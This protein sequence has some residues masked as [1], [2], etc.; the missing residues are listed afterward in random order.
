MTQTPHRSTTSDKTKRRYDKA[1]RSIYDELFEINFTDD[2]CKLIHHAAGKNLLPAVKEP[3]SVIIAKISEELICPADKKRFLHFF[4][5]EK[6]RANFVA[7]QKHISGEFRKLQ[8]D[9]EYH[10]ISL[11]LLPMEPLNGK[12]IYLCCLADIDNK[13]QL[14]LLSETTH[15]IGYDRLTGLP[16]KAAFY[17]KARELLL[18]NSGLQYY[19]ILIDIERFKLVN[20]LFG[21]LKGDELLRYL[22]NLLDDRF[23]SCNNTAYCHMEADLFAVCCP[24]SEELLQEF[25]AFVTE[26]LKAYPL[27]F[28]L[29]PN[30]GVYKVIEA[31]LP[32][33]LM[34][35]RALLA[36]RTIKDSCIKNH[37]FYENKLRATLLQKQE[38][39]GQME[40]ALKEGQFEI[41]LQPKVHLVTN[42]IVGVEALARWNHP[43]KGFLSPAEFIPI[44]EQ[45]G[46]ITKLDAYIWEESCFLLRKWLDAGYP[47]LPISVNVSRLDLF[48]PSL[49]QT[50]T[51]LVEKYKLDPHLLNLE[52]TETACMIRPEELKVIT[53]KLRDYGFSIHMDD[54]GSGYSAL[55]MLQDIAVDTLKLD[56]GFLSGF[57]KSGRSRSI[58]SSV[59]RM[60][61]WLN[62]PVIVEGVETEEQANFLRGIGCTVAQGYYFSEPLPVDKFE[63]TLRD[64]PLPK[65]QNNETG[66]LGK[67]RLD[68]VWMPDSTFN[69]IFDS[70][71]DAAGIYEFTDNNIELLRANDA[72]YNL[73]NANRESLYWAGTHLL[74]YIPDE[75]KNI[76]LAMITEAREKNK[77]EGTYRRLLPDGTTLW[78][79]ARI[80][81]L[82]G[83][84]QRA[85]CYALIKDVTPIKELES[86]LAENT[87]AQ[88]KDR[89]RLLAEHT[90]VMTYEY[91]CD[92]GTITHNYQ[93]PAGKMRET[94]I[95]NYLL[96]AKKVSSIHPDDLPSFLNLLKAKVLNSRETNVDFRADFFGTGY[97]WY[98][99]YSVG[100]PNESGR[101]YR[102][103]GKL[104]DIQNEKE[105]LEQIYKKIDLDQLTGIFTK[106]AAQKK[107]QSLLTN[108]AKEDFHALLMIDLDNFKEVND[109]FGHLFGDEVLQKTS[110]LLRRTFGDESIIGRFGG[111]EFTVMLPNS[112]EELTKES[113]NS[114]Y[115]QLGLEQ[116]I[117]IKCST[118][119]AISDSSSRDYM[120]LLA[121]ADSAMYSAKK[122]GK[123]RFAG[124]QN[125]ERN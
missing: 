3:F 122:G 53:K 13:K 44:F 65:K 92:S 54:F 64:N 29:I 105:T 120:C 67:T 116:D 110:S 35:D 84:E 1:L 98:R 55:N 16:S 48:D 81:L 2:V 6:I 60:T 113:L 104:M 52:I 15:H 27:V 47:L 95:T 112:T 23:I 46:F 10:W 49:F 20:D 71:P 12:E 26:K 59:I 119:F 18:T 9:N 51:G 89:Y 69:M 57:E 106:A 40:K 22:A 99:N 118:G 107:M 73:I 77:A 62:L 31:E 91:D 70:L 115:Q 33:N 123:C 30:F 86:E 87:E 50:I 56:L 111:D 25:M 75:D 14:D 94:S 8:E 83:N 124:H 88:N 4:E 37:A 24:F 68:E 79:N 42:E 45:N 85:L 80:H 121:Q 63:S 90:T 41:Y 101:I 93:N 28:N 82:A 38:I 32:I 114:F 78:L 7:G 58:L 97:H 76:L 102:I 109:Q 103:I 61:K 36:L 66:E 125:N 34:C 108:S 117:P 96:N 11:T 72:Y 100:I 39:T 19:I 43:T 74:D 5:F 21:M 17:Q